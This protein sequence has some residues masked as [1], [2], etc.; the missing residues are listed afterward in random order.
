MQT[1][2]RMSLGTISTSLV[3]EDRNQHG[4]SCTTW[5]DE[6]DLPEVG[7]GDHEGDEHEG[8]QVGHLLGQQTILAESNHS[9][10]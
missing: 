7:E 4:L 3:R 10:F 1:E 2:I 5:R 6:E 8:A 9:C